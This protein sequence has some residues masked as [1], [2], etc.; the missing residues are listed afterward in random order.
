M[1]RFTKTPYLVLFVVLAAASITTAWAVGTVTLSADNVIVTDNLAVDTST[2]VVDAAKNRVG[3]GTTSPDTRLHVVGDLTLESEIHCTDCVDADALSRF[4]A[5]RI[6]TNQGSILNND[7][8]LGEVRLVAGTLMPLNWARAEGQLL[9]I[10]NNLALF[11]LLGT[12]WGGDGRTSF[13]LPDLRDITPQST[14]GKGLNYIIC[15]DGL[16]PLI[17]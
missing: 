4:G 2:L 9:P 16:F 17:P 10:Q 3:I 7:C 14:N 12:Q 8:W 1:G 13:G 15:I 11:S 5:P 6:S